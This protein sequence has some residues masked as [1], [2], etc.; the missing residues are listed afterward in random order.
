MK[1]QG[2]KRFGFPL[3]PIRGEG[4]P[5]HPEDL[6]GVDSISDD[7][8][9]KLLKTYADCHGIKAAKNVFCS[10]PHL[11]DKLLK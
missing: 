5:I 11:L 2:I 7:L 10:R 1:E 9:S 8:Y 6:V 4:K 3:P